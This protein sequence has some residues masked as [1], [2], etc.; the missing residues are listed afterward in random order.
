M[1]TMEVRAF[2]RT[3]R[4]PRKR[5]LLIPVILMVGGLLLNLAHPTL[6]FIGTII[7]LTGSLTV[8]LVGM[9]FA[10]LWVSARRT[11]QIMKER[12]ERMSDQGDTLT[13]EEVDENDIIGPDPFKESFDET[14]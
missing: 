14:E 13:E 1:V 12:E 2:P 3:Q 4:E 5:I 10:D 6:R 9:V 11:K 7:A 8:F